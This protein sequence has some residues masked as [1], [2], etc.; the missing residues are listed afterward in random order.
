MW[1]IGALRQM[2]I[3]NAPPSVDERVAIASGEAKS[4]NPHKGIKPSETVRM[5]YSEWQNRLSATQKDRDVEEENHR[6]YSG[7]DFGQWPKEVLEELKKS[8]QKRDITQMNFIQKK[9]NSNV[10]DLV[11]NGYDVDFISTDGA[12][13]DTLTVFK[14]LYYFDKDI[15]DW[16]TELAV[17]YTNGTI[18]GSWLQMYPDYRHDANL[19]NI[20]IKALIPGSVLPDVNWVSNNSGDCRSLFTNTYLTLEQIKQT[21]PGKS[22]RIEQ[23]LLAKEMGQDTTESI[24]KGKAI[25]RFNLNDQYNNTYRVIQYHHMRT[26]FKEK[27]TAL[28]NNNQI[29]DVPNDA[30]E[31]WFQANNVNPENILSDKVKTDTYYVTTF[32]PDID[33]S[34]PLEDKQGL[35]QIGRLPFYHWS[36]NR[37]NGEDI[38]MVDQLKDSQRYINKMYGMAAE[39]IANSKH[40]RIIDPAM[41]DND[42]G[43]LAQVQEE[44]SKPGS[45]IIGK[46]N[47]SLETPNGIV[48][49]KSSNYA[50]NELDFAN[51]VLTMTDRLTP[52]SVSMEGIGN[53]RSGTHFNSKLE[54]GEVSKTLMRDS[55]RRFH[56]ELAEGYFYAAQALYGG[57]YRKFSNGTTTI[58][59]NKPTPDGRVIYDITDVPRSKATVTD[60]PKGLNRRINDR[61]FGMEYLNT[62]AAANDPISVSYA[63]EMIFDSFDNVGIV[64][65]KQML[66]DQERRRELLRTT[67]MAQLSQNEVNIIQMQMQKQQ[68]VNP[69]PP[70]PQPGAEGQGQPQPEGA[71]GEVPPEQLPPEGQEQQQLPPEV[72]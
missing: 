1:L 19:G 16:E 18:K 11:K 22:E 55:A 8:K 49:S 41:F 35:L 30:D 72:A 39:I 13:A 62:A 38:G 44:F 63:L 53:E 43:T 33:M 57:L 47:F 51:N 32:I 61:M 15:C 26:E 66:E 23:L 12:M 2:N 14:D 69:Q 58:E 20:G 65:R 45:T 34:K 7:T 60:N 68:L 6:M 54:Q 9:V 37:H 21:Y 40:T 59:I 25:P 48:E 64:K 5:L 70:V 67:D 56:N 42:A 50:G 46:E 24:T 3:R 52:Q 28:A 4:P 17:H 31:M 10:G 36:Y 71:E 27:K 29:L